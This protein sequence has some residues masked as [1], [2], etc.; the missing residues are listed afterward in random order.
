MLL[1]TRTPREAWM[2]KTIV[3]DGA[4]DEPNGKGGSKG[5]GTGGGGA[6]GGGW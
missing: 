4:G 3:D 6:G 5:G 2:K 1:S